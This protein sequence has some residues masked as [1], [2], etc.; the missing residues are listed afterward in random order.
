MAIALGLS[1][2]VFLVK[3]KPE[4]GEQTVCSTRAME[5]VHIILQ[6][7]VNSSRL[8]G[9]ALLPLGGLP[10]AV[11]AAKR[12]ARGGAHTLTLATADDSSCDPLAGALDT[13]GIAV[14]R[15]SENDVLGRFAAV[16]EGLH[17]DTVVVRL[18]ADNVFP[19]SDFVEIL[20][21]TLRASDV[22]IVGT[23]SAKG[24]PYGL[25]GEAFRLRALRQAA[26][27][28]S[29]PYDREHVTPWLY[30]NTRSAPF[31]RLDGEFDLAGLRC[32]LD[33]A[34]DYRTLTRVFEGVSDPVAI[35]WR[36]LVARLAALPVNSG[37]PK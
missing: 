31:D 30:R 22:D 8:P 21:S 34:D 29:A 20:V 5:P 9:K 14:F 4:E 16:T 25:S 13:A 37:V 10:S 11:L 33:T 27:S 18:T 2:T 36:E 24:L 32:T 15:G 19:D 35:R 17:D 1:Y 6:A 7:R 3:I 28:T 23:P 12:A 26:V